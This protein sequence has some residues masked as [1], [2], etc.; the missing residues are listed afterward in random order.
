MAEKLG[1]RRA[2]R[3]VD[4]LGAVLDAYTEE[5]HIGSQARE[6]VRFL[7][8]PPLPLATRPTY[9]LVF[10]AATS[11]LPRSARWRLRLPVAPLAEPLA[12][13]PRPRC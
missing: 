6:T 3:S 2:P 1:V 4:E 12:I 9:A 5:F 10:A 8:W 7:A 11:M 13:R